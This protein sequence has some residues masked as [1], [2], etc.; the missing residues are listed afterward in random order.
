MNGVTDVAS[1]QLLYHMTHITNLPS[2]LKCGGL[3]SHAVMQMNQLKHQDIANQDVQARRDRIK[4]PVG[5]G[6]TLHD[7][8]PFY[9]APRSPMLY[10]LHK[11]HLQQEDVVY[12][13]TSIA[14]IQVHALDF[15]FTDAHAIRRLTKFFTDPIHLNQI[16]WKVMTSDYWHDIDE[17]MSRKARRQAEFLIHEAVPLSACL[18]FA[19]FNER[20]KE[21]L[22]KMLQDAGSTLSVAVRRHFYY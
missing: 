10:Y 21:K 7:Y 11:Q 19:V 9:F 20:A 2:I 15:V 8:V 3:Q 22:E 1:N 17:D 14:S 16:D 13:M 5:K 12:F 6:G 18:G 4:I